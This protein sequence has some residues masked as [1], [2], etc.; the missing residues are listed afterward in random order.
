[1]V[2]DDSQEM[3]AI[4]LRIEDATAFFSEDSQVTLKN[5]HYY[6]LGSGNFI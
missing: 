2:C 3:V 1:V 5:T 4:V 6:C